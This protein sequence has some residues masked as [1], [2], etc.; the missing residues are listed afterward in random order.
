MKKVFCL[1]SLILVLCSSCSADIESSF[2]IKKGNQPEQ[3]ALN[4]GQGDTPYN[5]PVAITANDDKILILDEVNLKIKVYNYNG[6]YQKSISIPKGLLYYDIA[7]N[8]SEEILLLTDQGIYVVPKDERIKLLFEL[9]DFV[10]TPYYFFVDH[11]GNL[12]ISCLADQ[13]RIKTGVID[14]YGLFKEFKGSRIFSSYSGVI[15]LQ[16]SRENI[17]LIQNNEVVHNIT[18]NPQVIPFGI[19]D[20]F[21]VY[22]QEGT[23]T[24]VKLHKVNNKGILQSR[25][26][27]FESVLLF[28]DSSIIK[29]FRLNRK[30]QIIFLESDDNGFRVTVLNF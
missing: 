6:R 23:K 28:D 27:K 1:A 21:N 3:L 9:P 25:E 15:G 16:N 17:Q 19:T 18:I 7:I 29:Y 8:K 14:S 13:G 22:L 24:G 30:G 2:V 10:S 12:V 5:G 20:D 11:L 26:I 4:I